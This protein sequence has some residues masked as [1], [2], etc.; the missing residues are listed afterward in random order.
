MLTMIFRD[1][2]LRDLL[3]DSCI[4]QPKKACEWEEGKMVF[5]FTPNSPYKLLHWNFNTHSSEIDFHE[6]WKMVKIWDRRFIISVAYR[7]FIFVLLKLDVFTAILEIA[8]QHFLVSQE[9]LKGEG[10]VWV[11]TKISWTYNYQKPLQLKY[12]FRNFFNQSFPLLSLSETLHAAE[13]CL[14][15]ISHFASRFVV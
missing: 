6:L 7:L 11:E 3:S 12:I 1:S 15:I 13:L 9:R 10:N 8:L 5:I 2:F 4:W 14:A